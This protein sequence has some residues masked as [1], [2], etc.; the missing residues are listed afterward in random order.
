[1]VATVH[2]M[3][4]EGR[5]Y[6]GSLEISEEMT[7]RDAPP[8]V[9]DTFPNRSSAD[10][11]RG[12]LAAEGIDAK[13]MSD[14]AGGLHPDL[15]LNRGVNLLVADRD[16]EAARSVLASGRGASGTT[17]DAALHRGRTRLIAAAVSVLVVA[18]VVISV[19]RSF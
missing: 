18:I 3:V 14:D 1:M 19:V 10:V 15:A 4:R 2:R 8:V 11:A 6:A 17:D 5:Y 7:V 13:I 16:A 9:V 12:A